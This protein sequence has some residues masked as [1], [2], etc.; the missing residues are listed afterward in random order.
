MD[1]NR[2]KAKK[3]GIGRL[4]KALTLAEIVITAGILALVCSML[5]LSFVNCIILNESS[6]NLTR[7]SS[8]AQYVIEDIKNA[9]VSS[10]QS[11]INNGSW[12]WGVADISSRGL[13]A[14]DAES[15]DTN[16]IGTD[17]DLLDVVVNINWQDRGGRVRNITIE[18]LITEP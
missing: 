10:L 4:A 3:I 6:R 17:P 12:D 11:N 7:A 9:D 18:T 13:E 16:E 5:F 14:L 1:L 2:T 8:H 15:I